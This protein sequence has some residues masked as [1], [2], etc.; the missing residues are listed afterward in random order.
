MYEVGTGDVVCP[1]QMPVETGFLVVF[2]FLEFSHKVPGG[3]PGLQPS[4]HQ[5]SSHFCLLSLFRFERM[6][7]FASPSLS[8]LFP[9]SVGAGPVPEKVLFCRQFYL[10]LYTLLFFVKKK[11]I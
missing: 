8:S 1:G 10:L 2:D 11:I 3:P 4:E 5:A 6:V 9:A 7:W